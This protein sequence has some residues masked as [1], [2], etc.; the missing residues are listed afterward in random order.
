MC[1]FI[2]LLRPISPH[3]L[4]QLSGN[5]QQITGAIVR[6]NECAQAKR[7]YSATAVHRMVSGQR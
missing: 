6:G 3:G 7:D 4:G 1:L 5:S 2:L